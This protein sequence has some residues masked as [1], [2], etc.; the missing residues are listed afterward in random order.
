MRQPS[1]F[2]ETATEWNEGRR[3]TLS[4]PGL[5]DLPVCTPPEFRGEPGFWT[6]EHLFIA[7]A[8]VCLM[9]TFLGIAENSRL[10]IAGYGSSARG[11]LE[12]VDGEG[13]RFTEI[14]LLPVVELENEGD[15]ELAGRVMLR[16]AKGCLV[17]RS[18]KAEASVT[19]RFEIRA[20]VAA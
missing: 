18:M 14:Q 6:P 8:E 9:A 17:T 13:Y 15:R 11:K 4:S 19:P 1:Y 10:R 7:A 16:A 20:P 5:P 3:G 12:W 2:Y